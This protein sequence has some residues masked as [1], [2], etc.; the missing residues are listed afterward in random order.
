MRREISDQDFRNIQNI[1]CFLN[2]STGNILILSSHIHVSM[3]SY[4][5]SCK[6]S[7]LFTT[8]VTSFSFKEF[9]PHLNAAKWSPAMLCEDHLRKCNTT[10]KQKGKEWFSFIR[11]LNKSWGLKTE[12]NK[13][14][15]CKFP[16]NLD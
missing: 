13:N 12:M 10:R 14:S 4:M 6:P 16:Q 11:T 7:V 5:F 9:E 2:V 3:F 8:T 1:Q 15:Y